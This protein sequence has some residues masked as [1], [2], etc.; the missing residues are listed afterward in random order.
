[1]RQVVAVT[2]DTFSRPIPSPVREL[3]PS[4]ETCEECHWPAKFT[5]DRI[6]VIPKYLEDEENSLIHSVL[7]MHI[8]GGHG[9]GHG[10][11]SWHIDPSKTTTYLP[12]DEQRQEIGIV[13]VTE[14]DGTVT[15]Y[16]ASGLELTE[17]EVAKAEFRTMDCIDCH[18]RPT[19]IFH[20]PAQAVD[21]RM[22]SGGIDPSLPYVKRVGVEALEAAVGE[23][24]DLDRIAAHVRD[25]YARDYAELAEQQR[26]T[27]DK[28]VE[29]LQGIYKR[30]VFPD[31]KVT[32]NTYPNNLGHND[33]FPG[34]FRCHDDSHESKTGQTIRGDCSLCHT[35]LAWDEED[36]DILKQLELK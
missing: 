28:A 17:E 16:R 4:K 26:G 2:L 24:G 30:N 33:D 23:P 21:L 9:G 20:A 19:H 27:I 22:A 3:R 29:E 18:N 14:A 35:L 5:G 31:M 12:L 32:W 36:P 6:R 7:L 10:I 15:E 25:F 13:R 11:H 1:V 8:G 34:C